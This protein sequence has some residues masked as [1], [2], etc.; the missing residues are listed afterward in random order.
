M[1]ATESMACETPVVAYAVGGLAANICHGRTGFLSEPGNPHA[2]SHSLER[3]LEHDD[4]TGMGR[5]ARL[6]VMRFKWTDIA[7]RTLELYEDVAANRPCMCRLLTG[8]G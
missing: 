6:S 7:R 8:T 5:H 4:L 3:A 1:V 2:L